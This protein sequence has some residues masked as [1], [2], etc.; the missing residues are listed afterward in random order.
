MKNN[1]IITETLM[2][3]T[4]LTLLTLLLWITLVITT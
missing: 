1:K 4:F 3:I 2:S